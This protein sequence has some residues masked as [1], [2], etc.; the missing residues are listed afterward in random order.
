MP[1]R[2]KT[3][4][5]LTAEP[6]KVEVLWDVTIS[7]WVT[8][9]SGVRHNNK[10]WTELID[11]WR[12]KKHLLTPPSRVLLEKLTGSAARQEIPRI[13]GTRRFLTVLTS[14]RHL[15]LSWPNSIQSPQLPPTSWRSILILSSHDERSTTQLKHGAWFILFYLI[16]LTGVWCWP[17]P[18]T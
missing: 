11:R 13:F 2:A 1:L 8:A 16:T 3:F 6:L 12:W 4:E 15:S 9:T 14:A 7:R 5:V 10:N 18:S 17:L